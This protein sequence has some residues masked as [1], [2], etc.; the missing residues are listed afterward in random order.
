M[1]LVLC[2]SVLRPCAAHDVV[3]AATAGGFD[4]V[5]LWG[6]MVRRSLDE[7][8]SLAALRGRC[9]EL[10]IAVD[11]VEPVR[12]WVPGAPAQDGLPARWVLE[13]GAALGARMVL[14]STADAG[15]AT[16]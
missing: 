8:W 10:G 1:Q 14:A 13:T 11:C 12:D 2:G 7:G 5:S 3:A 9:D 4:A 15:A 6:A 16:A